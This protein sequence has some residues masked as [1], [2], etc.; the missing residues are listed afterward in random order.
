M[1]TLHRRHGRFLP[2]INTGIQSLQL[3]VQV[4]EQLVALDAVGD[5]V[6]GPELGGIVG[7]WRRQSYLKLQIERRWCEVGR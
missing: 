2:R 5:G 4:L 3:L 1:G 7:R 6:G